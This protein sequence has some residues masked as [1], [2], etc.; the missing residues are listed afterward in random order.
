L[1]KFSDASSLNGEG[2]SPSTPQ[3]DPS[4]E[5]NYIV[6]NNNA[7][8]SSEGE[9]Q[10]ANF[11]GEHPVLSPQ[12]NVIQDD[13]EVF[14]DPEFTLEHNVPSGLD[15]EDVFQEPE[16]DFHPDYPPLLKWTRDHPQD[17]IIGNPQTRVL[18][19]LS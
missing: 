10:N 3:N 18:P 7:N 12:N 13:D 4:K 19:E 17:H 8:A 5:E 6:H 11:E 16:S 14:E 15:N 9:T 1:T 2:G